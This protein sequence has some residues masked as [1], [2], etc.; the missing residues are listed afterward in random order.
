M[1][2]FIRRTA[3]QD[4]QD[5]GFPLAMAFDFRN[6]MLKTS[7]LDLLQPSAVLMLEPLAVVQLVGA[8]KQNQASGNLMVAAPMIIWVHTLRAMT[9]H[10]LRPH[11][12]ALW[13]ELA[14]GFP[15][16]D[17][18]AATFYSMTGQRLDTTGKGQFP[19][20]LTPE[21]L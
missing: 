11:G 5:L 13:R 6:E 21:R 12:R 14:R 19:D 10:E 4:G 18:G 8:V 2:D 15:H 17:Y 16:V 9:S 3:V 7:G 20:G 1:V